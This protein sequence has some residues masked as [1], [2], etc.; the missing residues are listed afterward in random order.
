MSWDDKFVQEEAT[1]LRMFQCG[2]SKH[3]STGKHRY[4]FFHALSIRAATVIS[5]RRLLSN[6]QITFGGC[7]NERTGSCKRP[8]YINML[9]PT[10]VK[11]KC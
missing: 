9:F 8:V 4:T 3:T 6:T 5:K 10:V 7:K 11:K 2:T 1:T